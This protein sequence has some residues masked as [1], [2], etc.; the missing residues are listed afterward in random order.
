M[1]KVGTVR[2]HGKCTAHPDYNPAVDGA[3]A[4]GA[5]CPRCELLLS[6]YNT[7]GHLVHLMNKAAAMRTEEQSKRRLS[8]LQENQLSL[9]SFAV[10][11]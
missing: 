3:P 7:H 5:S 4:S 6:I 8:F 10:D 11:S 1:L 9:F 2:F